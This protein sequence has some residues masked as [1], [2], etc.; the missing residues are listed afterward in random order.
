MPHG[1]PRDSRKEQFWRD[2]LRRWRESGL[3]IRAYCRQRGLSEPSFYAWRRILAERDPLA[4]PADE[5]APVTFVP[6]TVQAA[7][8]G[9]A[10][11]PIEVVL[12]NGRRLRVPFGVAAGVV[13]ELLAVLEEAPC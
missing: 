1:Q 6:L 7:T 9:P 11:P 10:E 5:A 2:V 3:S 8:A 4:R 13:R 12:V